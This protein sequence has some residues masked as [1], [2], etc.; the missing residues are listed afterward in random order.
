MLTG[1]RVLYIVSLSFKII[2]ETGVSS[3][4]RRIEAVTNTAAIKF[5][6]SEIKEH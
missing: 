5:Y 6:N 3:G 4:V 1:S 2:S